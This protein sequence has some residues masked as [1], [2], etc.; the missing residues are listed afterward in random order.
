MR[1]VMMAAALMVVMG[2]G[3]CDRAPDA[4]HE[5]GDAVEGD[6]AGECTDMDDNDG[7]GLIDCFDPGCADDEHCA[8]DDDSA[9]DDDDAT[10]DDDDTA[11][12]DDDTADD[13]D[14][15]SVGDPW[16]DID[17]GA[18]HTC[19][20]RAS[21]RGLCWGDNADGQIDVPPGDYRMITAG[22]AHSCGLHT[23]GTIECWGSN[24][25]GQCDVPTDPLTFLFVDAGAEHT[26]AIAPDTSVVCWGNDDQQQADT[27]GLGGDY[28]SLA[29]GAFH[30]CGLKS[31]GA[32]V[33][34]GDDQ[35][36]Q[37][38]TQ[39]ERADQIASGAGN[40][41]GVL[42]GELACWG[43]PM[44]D[45]PPEETFAAV[46]MFDDHACAILD[47]G[48]IECWGDNAFGQIDAVIGA[49]VDVAV[50]AYHSCGIL[51]SGDLLCW[52]DDTYGQIQT[53]P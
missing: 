22:G 26:C 30:G 40:S 52:G 1:S 51:A 19:G 41:C 43:A 31:G 16:I 12:D 23:D 5:T 25:R 14:D 20:V 35:Y 2:L 29:I 50:G 38:S 34:W 24:S 28:Q 46:A 9:A 18:V 47:D 8:D 49:Y 6:E 11:D 3:G 15:T 45:D 4:P 27:V 10:D 39:P 13:D 53:P 7:N 48:L 42:A 21:G 36:G 37:I 44:A 32:L 33:C 17:A